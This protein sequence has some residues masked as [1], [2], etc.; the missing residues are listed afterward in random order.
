LSS[1]NYADLART[2]ML[3]DEGFHFGEE[4]WARIVYDFAVAYNFSGE[5]PE[6]VVGYL[7]P[8]YYGRTASFVLE[9]KGMSDIMVE[10]LIEGQALLYEENKEYLIKRWNDSKKNQQKN[11]AAV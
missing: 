2:A 5:D 7:T 6:L 9:A 3:P 8:I 1:A 10:A 11:G 4:L